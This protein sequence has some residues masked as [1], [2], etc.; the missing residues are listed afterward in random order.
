MTGLNINVLMLVDFHHKSTNDIL[1]S[2]ESDQEFQGL[3][4]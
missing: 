2:A 4:E 1:L 3:V